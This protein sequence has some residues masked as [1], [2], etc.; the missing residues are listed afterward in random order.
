MGD[1]VYTLGSRIVKDANLYIY[2]YIYIMKACVNRSHR[3]SVAGGH[4]WDAN[5]LVLPL[6]GTYEHTVM[7]IAY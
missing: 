7:Q 2:T 6:A 1:L 4:I 5:Q 3:A